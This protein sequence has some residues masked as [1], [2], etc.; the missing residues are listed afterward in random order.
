MDEL[1]EKLVGAL[2][3]EK[4]QAEGG[5][6]VLLKIAKEKLGAD[7]SQ[8][9]DKVHGIQDT[10]DKAPDA[11]GGIGGMLSNL[12]DK[13]GLGGLGDLAEAAN[14]FSK[15]KLDKGM[16]DNFIGE[17][18]EFFQSKGGDTFKSLIEGVLKK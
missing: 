3:I 18:V 6:G 9:E 16:I 7:F 8:I 17:I 13:A 4:G 10:I 5:V 11:E 1:I 12:A 15:L 14:G 2:G